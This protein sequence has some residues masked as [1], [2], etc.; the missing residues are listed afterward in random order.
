[1]PP[2]KFISCQIC[3]R[4]FGSASIN[5]HIPQCY[6]KAMKRWQLNPTGPRPVMPAPVGGR[7]GGGRGGGGGGG[8]DNAPVGKG[9]AAAR[10]LKGNNV[11]MMGDEQPVNQNLHPCSKCGR[12]FNFD[13]IA[14]HEGVCKGDK[15]RAVYSS[16][17][18][19]MPDDEDAGS[20]L[21][22]RG[23]SGKGRKNQAPAPS[24]NVRKPPSVWRQQHEE[25]IQAMRAARQS[26][27]GAKSM[28]ATSSGGGGAGATAAPRAAPSQRRVPA[29]F[30]RQ[31]ETMKANIASGGRAARAQGSSISTPAP[32]NPRG[33]V[34]RRGPPAASGPRGGAF[35][36]SG[37]R[38]AG[39]GPGG[40]SGAAGGGG[41]RGGDGGGGRIIND[42]TSS[43]GM[44][45]AFGRS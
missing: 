4:G 30:V 25:F 45:Q 7:G 24:R 22:S 21:P 40:A 17:S 3:G 41:G 37:D 32:A 2:P 33:G 16:T 9:S 29:N 20:F 28:W 39:Y 34:T 26:N 11:D 36:G 10:S 6:E 1:M 42:N 15:K 35:G 38:F 13:R 23:Y 19:R 8:I 18:H 27:A 14:Y 5:I 31:D 43:I 44:M 12:K